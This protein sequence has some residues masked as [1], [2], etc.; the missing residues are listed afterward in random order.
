M[1]QCGRYRSCSNM[2][3]R[4]GNRMGLAYG[5]RP[6]GRRD[7]DI[8]EPREYDEPHKWGMSGGWRA[9]LVG[10]SVSPTVSTLG[11]SGGGEGKF[12]LAFLRE[13]D[14]IRGDGG[15]VLGVDGDNHQSSLL[16]PPRISA[17]VKV[18]G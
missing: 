6:W 12:D 13:D 18:P 4:S 5:F 1:W 10:V 9:S 17:R 2:G 7:S 15:N 8:C 3:A 14:N 16:G 11:G